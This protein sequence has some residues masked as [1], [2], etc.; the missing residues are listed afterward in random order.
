M[1]KKRNME[2]LNTEE[3]MEVLSDNTRLT[4]LRKLAHQLNEVLKDQT[5]I[6]PKTKQKFTVNN[7][8]I[9]DIDERDEHYLY[10]AIL[11]RKQ[12]ISSNLFIDLALMYQYPYDELFHKYLSYY[13]FFLINNSDLEDEWVPY[14]MLINPD[15]LFFF[16][17]HFFIKSTDYNVLEWMMTLTI[18]GSDNSKIRQWIHTLKSRGDEL[19]ETNK[20]LPKHLVYYDPEMVQHLAKDLIQMMQS[21]ELSKLETIYLLLRVEGFE[22]D[23]DDYRTDNRTTTQIAFINFCT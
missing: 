21:G 3:K 5:M 6:E 12:Y 8:Y 9:T 16:Y 20:D 19:G 7:K 14:F 10:F 1:K 18:L 22:D 23:T 2:K 11:T 4:Q 17:G 15:K 13:N